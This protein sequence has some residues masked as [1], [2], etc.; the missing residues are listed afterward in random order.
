M[1]EYAL[2]VQNLR[3]TYRRGRG[4]VV[5]AVDD[6]SFTV[7][8]GEVVGLLGANGAGKTTT[9]KCVCTLVRPTSGAV[10]V[11][12]VETASSPRA[13]LKRVAAVLEGNRN[14]YW[15][16]TCRQ[17]LEFF[18]GLHGISPRRARPAVERLLASFR[19][20]AKAD[21]LARALSRGMQQKLALG[22]ALIKDTDVLLLDEPTLGLDVQTSYELRDLLRAIAA[23]GRTIVLSSH[24]MAVVQDLCDRVVIIHHGRV[25][26]DDRIASLINGAR[27]QQYRF[28]LENKL[29][30]LPER[31]LRD[32]FEGVKVQP[33]AH[34]T[35]V[36]LELAEAGR[37]Y[38][39]IDLL[40]EGGAELQ[41]VERRSPTLEEV[42]L[43]ATT[44]S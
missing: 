42:F 32:A 41:G 7:K 13:A 39:V 6:V 24:D 44:R 16:L 29:S 12:G 37:V 5:V 17:N 11:M 9:I 30:E 10:R 4:Q 43:S 3:K 8:R 40:R 20:E 36:E 28:R 14:I 2:E 1:G 18:A 26:S 35:T 38:E 25:I 33:G 34:G 23:E 21:T 27:T 15:T 31:R 22:C 19:L